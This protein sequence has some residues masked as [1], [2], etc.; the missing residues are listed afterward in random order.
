MGPKPD[1]T[2]VLVRRQLCEDRDAQG[3]DPVMR[4]SEI[5]YVA[6]SQV[7][8]TECLCPSGCIH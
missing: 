3:E 5:R 6:A 4:K 7:L 2:C 1:T 8:L